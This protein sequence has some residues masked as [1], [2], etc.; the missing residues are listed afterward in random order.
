MFSQKARTIDINGVS[1]PIDPDFRI[2]CKYAVAVANH[3]KK[4]LNHL[5]EK[6]FFAGL[7]ENVSGEAAV[8][9]MTSFYIQGLAPKHK[10]Q[11]GKTNT[12]TPVPLFDFEEDEAFF[13]A[14]FLSCYRIDL[15][16]AKLHWLDF[17]ALFRGLPDECRLKR[18]I[19]I[20]A[21]DL[22]EIKSKTERSRIRRLKDIHSLKCTAKKRYKNVA[23]R[24]AAM[25]ADMRQMH[26][27][28]RRKS[29]RR[30]KL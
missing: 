14:D 12:T 11:K 21:A 6:F 1:T 24:D 25:I 8:N 18:I 3:D 23:E 28:A 7:P 29:E 19:S 5:A 20:R 27:D 22:S 30:D 10:D 16:K 17:C 15:T 13:Y 2:M 9:A 4:A 26:M